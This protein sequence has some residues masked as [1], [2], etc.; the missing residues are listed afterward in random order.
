[1]CSVFY[2]F[3]LA[4]NACKELEWEGVCHIAIFVLF[5]I[6]IADIGVCE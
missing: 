5:L 3:V 4:L 6:H 1:M 2:L